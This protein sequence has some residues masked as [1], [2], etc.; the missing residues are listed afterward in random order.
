MDGGLR[1]NSMK[2][3]SLKRRAFTLIELLVVVA[4]IALLISILLPSLSQAREKARTVKCIAN[5]KTIGHVMHMYFT[6]HRDWFP[7]EKDNTY[8]YIHGFY[9]GGHPGRRD[10]WG[11]TQARW[12]DTPYGRP[13]NPYL[14]DDLPDWDVRPSEG[15]I[16]RLVREQLE[17][18]QCPSDRGGWWQTDDATADYADE[19]THWTTGSSYDFNYHYV[20]SWAIRFRQEA[21][22][23]ELGN[24]FLARQRELH[25]SKFIVLYED[26]FDIAQWNNF[27]RR[28]WHGGWNTHS[29]LFLDAHAANMLTDTTKGNRGV[30]WKSASGSGDSAYTVWWR[31]VNDPDYEYRLMSAP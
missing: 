26:P 17:V 8:N 27:P 1:R 22:W 21:R 29:F 25:A 23:Q 2:T 4:I 30:G 18:Y 24:A 5:L 15:A 7:Y 28:G 9:Y 20:L 19:P 11:Y 10:W 31:D 14:Y 6:E 16:F 3:R 12:R 13:F